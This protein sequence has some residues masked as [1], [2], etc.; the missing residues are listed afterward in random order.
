MSVVALYGRFNS[1]VR[2]AL[3]VVVALA[4]LAAFLMSSPVSPAS[5][6]EDDDGVISGCVN[7][8]NGDLRV[9]RVPGQ[10]ASTEYPIEFISKDGADNTEQELL[11]RIDELEEELNQRID[12]EVQTINLRI[13]GETTTLNLRIDNEVSTL[14]TRIDTEV[15]TLN[16]LI[17][18][19]GSSFTDTFGEFVSCFNE[20]FNFFLPL[21]DIGIEPVVID[22][23]LDIGEIEVFPG[24]SL[25]IP[26]IN[27]TIL[28][29]VGVVNCLANVDLDPNN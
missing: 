20:T 27:L 12:D 5:A 25:P 28:D 4:A 21:P 8:Y 15:T 23:P 2:I 19:L 16:G 13:D 3:A 7:R 29:P 26:D 1:G 6:Q 10:C 18:A 17:N 14:N 22:F 24:F 11:D 9:P